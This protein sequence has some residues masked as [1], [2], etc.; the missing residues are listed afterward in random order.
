LKSV[1]LYPSSNGMVGGRET[2]QA[3]SDYIIPDGP[4]VRSYERLAA[5]GWRLN[6][7]SAPHS[8][9]TKAPKNKTKFT[10]DLCGYNVWAKPPSPTAF[11]ACGA[12]SVKEHE[13]VIMRA[14]ERGTTSYEPKPVPVTAPSYEIEPPLKRKRG[15]PKGS[16]N[17]PKDVVRTNEIT[18]HEG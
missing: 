4:F 1:G 16:K 8:N 15:R 17:K 10:C 6:L 12:C 14:T 5:T 2:G 18:L 3:M 9:P 13:A 11:P 7:Q